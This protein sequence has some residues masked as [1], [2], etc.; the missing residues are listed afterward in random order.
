MADYLLPKGMLD[1]FDVADVEEKYP[2][3]VLET[4]DEEV[5]LHIHIDERDLWGET[6]HDLHPNGFTESRQVN[7]FSD[8]WR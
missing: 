3:K 5:I 1:F 4:G 8:S 6:W 7:G 2:S